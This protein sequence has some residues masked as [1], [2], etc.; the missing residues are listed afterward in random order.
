MS[1]LQCVAPELLEQHERENPGAAERAMRKRHD[2][3]ARLL[4]REQQR[5]RVAR[6]DRVMTAHRAEIAAPAPRPRERK[7]APSRR[8][9]SSSS[10]SSQDPGDSDPEPAGSRPGIAEGVGR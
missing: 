7:A 1:K 3:N 8:S 9:S 5:R 6:A 2:L 4:M 10:T